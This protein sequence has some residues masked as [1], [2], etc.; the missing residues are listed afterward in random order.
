MVIV[1]AKFEVRS[2]TCYRDIAIGVFG[3]VANPN[4]GEEEAIWV[5]N[6]TVAKSKVKLW[7]F[8]MKLTMRKLESRGYPT[9][10]THGR[11]MRRFDTVPECDGHTDGRIYCSQ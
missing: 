1:L 5:R 9:V 11:S 10:K 8:A 6:G 2:F 4:L 7:K 3:W